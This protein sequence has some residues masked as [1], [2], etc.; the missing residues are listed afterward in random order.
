MRLLVISD[1][2]RHIGHVIHLLEGEH[3]F[4][5][6]IHLGD[7]VEDAMDLQNI[8]GL[9]V[10]YVPGNC[11]WGNHYGASEKVL[12][13]MGKRIYIC[14]GHKSRVK[15]DND[16]LRQMIVNEGYDM[17]LYG[18]THTAR[19]DYEGDSILMNPGS[20]SLPRDGQPSFG[21]I[22]IDKDGTIHTNIGRIQPRNTIF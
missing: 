18:H 14:H 2:H 9:P 7:M 3:R 22:H 12:E 20:I 11:D 16:I 13:F 19:I 6:L 21:V 8:F 10:Y 15:Y 1:T 5:A 4:D 17:A